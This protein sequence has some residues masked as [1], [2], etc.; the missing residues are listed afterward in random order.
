MG[1]TF[2]C[3]TATEAIKIQLRHILSYHPFPGSPGLCSSVKRSSKI[4]ETA[5]VAFIPKLTVS[6]QWQP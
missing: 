2:P 5:E 3:Q 1:Q 4:Y 6:M